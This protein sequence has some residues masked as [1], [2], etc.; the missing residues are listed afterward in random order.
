MDGKDNKT[1]LPF[2]STGPELFSE[3]KQHPLWKGAA[4]IECRLINGS[5]P[6]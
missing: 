1:F 2:V 4:L 6:S 3:K 5:V